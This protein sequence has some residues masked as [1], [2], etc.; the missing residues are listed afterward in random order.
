MR[1]SSQDTIS[2]TAR[3]AVVSTSTIAASHWVCSPSPAAAPQML[4][5]GKRAAAMPV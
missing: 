4:S 3:I 5:A 2:T 1:W